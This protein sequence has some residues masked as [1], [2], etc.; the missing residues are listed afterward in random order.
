MK[1]VVAP[2]KFRGSLSATEAARA[3]AVGILRADDSIE[4]VQ[5]P[6]ADGGE[7]T[8]EAL[9]AAT[10]GSF[11]EFVVT[12]P[13]GE[14]VRASFGILGDGR[15]AVIEMATAS[16]LALVPLHLRDPL[17]T[18]TRGTGELLLAAIDEGVDRVLMG[19]GGSATNDGGAGFAQSLGFRLL[20]EEGRELLPG[21]GALDRLS[22]I[23]PGGRDE[24][25]D[26]VEIRVACDVDNP[27]CGPL[28]A[29]RI[30]GPQKGADAAMV[31]RLDQNLAYF[32]CVIA[33]DL[34]RE[35]ALIP[36]AGAAGGLGA[37][38][39]AFTNATLEP[40]VAVVARAVGLL[41]AM[42]SADLVI[43]GEGAIDKS[44]VGGKTAVGVA[45]IARE[46]GIPV[47]ALAGTIGPGAGLVLNEGIDAYLSLCDRPMSLRDAIDSASALLANAA[48]SATRI[49]LAGR[50]GRTH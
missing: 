25:L 46:R 7:G 9:V 5:I 3:I 11:R 14:P 39:L 48:E 37:G 23:D 24:R 19:I 18:T 8:V 43:T 12:G 42:S 32:S 15:T 16:G 36:G 49:F 2:D 10:S 1:I 44:S 34:G 17:R 27:L 20:D 35:V 29:S 21:G 4:I 31:D 50:R 30:F 41:D 28:G 13:L 22:S 40:G 45:R 38:L 26:R 47:I 6:M 33:R